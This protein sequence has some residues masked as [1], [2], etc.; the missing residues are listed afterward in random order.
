MSNWIFNKIWLS[1]DIIEKRG[2]VSRNSQGFGFLDII[3]SVELGVLFFFW[4][5]NNNNNFFSQ[6]SFKLL[7]NFMRQITLK[8]VLMFCMSDD[9]LNLHF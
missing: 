4:V 1:C 7:L 9:L 2:K 5:E 3:N 8:L 6:I